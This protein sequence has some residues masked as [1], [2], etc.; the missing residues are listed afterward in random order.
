MDGR[1]RRGGGVLRAPGRRESARIRE[2][3]DVRGEFGPAC[4]ALIDDGPV[5]ALPYPIETAQGE[6]IEFIA[7]AR[8]FVADAVEDVR[9]HV[10]AQIFL[11]RARLRE[12][13]NPIDDRLEHLLAGRVEEER[14]ILES[15]PAGQ[16]HPADRLTLH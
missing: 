9:V 16:T 8:L 10:R 3:V 2:R 13:R 1:L 15:C 12:R 5:A 6:A 14:E 4:P 11:D 7:G